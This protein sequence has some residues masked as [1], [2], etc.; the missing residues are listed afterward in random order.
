MFAVFVARKMAQQLC[1][2]L[3]AP[4]ARFS[5]RCQ[6]GRHRVPTHRG[7]WR[8]TPAPV[9]SIDVSPGHDVGSRDGKG[10]SALLFCCNSVAPLLLTW[11]N[12]ENTVHTIILAEGG[13]QPSC[14][15]R[16]CL[17]FVLTPGSTPHMGFCSMNAFGIVAASSG[18]RGGVA[19][20]GQS[21]RP[22]HHRLERLSHLA[23]RGISS[24]PGAD[25]FEKHEQL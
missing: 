4:R 13:E 24:A 6:R 3:N 14:L 8:Q 16:R 20:N 17:C 11:E 9:E 7:T 22:C 1:P 10:Y 23:Q 18:G 21:Q 2:G 19:S 5:A 12:R 25:F 15:Q